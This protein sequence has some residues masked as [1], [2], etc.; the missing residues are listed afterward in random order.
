M[1]KLSGKIAVVTGASRGI[2]AAIAR[3]LAA[4]GATVAVNYSSSAKAA[5][6]LVAE[7]KAAGGTAAA[8]QADVS[9]AA[10]VRKLFE[11]VHKHHGRV[12]ILVNNAGVWANAPLSE[13][14]LEHYRKV[15]DLNVV[16]PL[17]AT[18]E[19]IKYMPASGGRVINISSGA[20]R[21]LI[22]GGS[23]YS[24]SKAALEALTFNWAV[25]LGSRKITVNAVAPGIT[26]T[27]M[28]A[29]A[30]EDF[31]NGLIARTPLGRIGRPED[32][33]DVVSFVASDDARWI[34]G[35]TIN[36]GGGLR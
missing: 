22:A 6:D 28:V 10:A 8:L 23:V 35:Q 25:E 17:L 9:D 20:A 27:E 4:D 29:G 15:F 33:A 19:A 2:G 16:G 21:N 5:T 7:I 31:K 1:G 34:T 12:D 26:E 18:S 3:R 36:A 32:I 14:T 11:A 13:F 24:A 30:P